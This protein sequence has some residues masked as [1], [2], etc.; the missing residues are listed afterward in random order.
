MKAYYDKQN[1]VEKT[2]F[3][4][5]DRVFV[6]NPNIVVDKH[7][8]KLTPQ[9][10]GPFRILELSENSALVSFDIAG[11][12]LDY[13]AGCSTH[14]TVRLSAVTASVPPCA[15]LWGAKN[16]FELAQGLQVSES[17]QLSTASRAL[18]FVN[19]SPLASADSFEKPTEE[20]LV[21][22]LAKLAA[23]CTER[24]A[25]FAEAVYKKLVYSTADHQA[26]LKLLVAERVRA[27]LDDK[28]SLRGEPVLVLGGSNAQLL[29]DFLGATF[30]EAPT[31]PD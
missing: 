7:S 12:L 11:T 4:V 10:E 23:A 8:S 17:L 20:N 19:N 16:V 1:S 26:D 3:L 15:A 22:V 21:R 18:F 29:A 6:Y 24:S 5:S 28:K 9:W 14:K 2:V 31:V 13:S 25:A 27:E 30:V